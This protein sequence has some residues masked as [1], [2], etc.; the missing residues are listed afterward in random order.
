MLSLDH[1]ADFLS[2]LQVSALEKGYVNTR[3]LLTGNNADLLLE[4]E[5]PLAL[6]SPMTRYALSFYLCSRPPLTP[7]EQG[8]LSK[9]Q[10]EEMISTA[11]KYAS[12]DE[13]ERSRIEKKNGL[14]SYAYSLK[15]T[16]SDSKVAGKIDAD[17]KAKLDSAINETV[18]WLDS[19]QTATVEEYDAKKTELEG[20]ANPIMTKLYS[21]G[22][23]GMPGGGNPMGGGGNTSAAPDVEEVD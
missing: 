17:E 2:V 4:P 15:S 9:E 5:K 7:S 16:L 18:E 10:I 8:R 14:E 23:D 12:E 21:G 13:A 3:G 1:N 20:I 22:E 11:A 6:P 19:N